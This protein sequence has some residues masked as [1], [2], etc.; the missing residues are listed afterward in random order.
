KAKKDCQKLESEKLPAGSTLPIVKFTLPEKDPHQLYNLLSELKAQGSPQEKLYEVKFLKREEDS[1]VEMNE[2][3]AAK[4]PDVLLIYWP[5]E[6]DQEL[7]QPI[8]IA[9]G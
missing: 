9:G 4:Y 1:G 3:E 6:M 5:S 8:G 2:N 7:V